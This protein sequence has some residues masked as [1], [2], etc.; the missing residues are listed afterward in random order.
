M[1]RIMAAENYVNYSKTGYNITQDHVP[2]I[3]YNHTEDSYDGIVFLIAHS[4]FKGCVIVQPN[5]G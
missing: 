3:E 2:I 1:K 5:Q 4:E